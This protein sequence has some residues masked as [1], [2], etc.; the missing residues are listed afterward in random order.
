MRKDS[1]IPGSHR[2]DQDLVQTR[3]PCRDSS[4]D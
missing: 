3:K 4:F 2:F 1:R